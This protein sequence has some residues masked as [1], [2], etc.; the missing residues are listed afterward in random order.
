MRKQKLVAAVLKH[1]TVCRQP[2]KV[3]K[4]IGSRVLQYKY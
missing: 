1:K 2:G 3:V 4:Y